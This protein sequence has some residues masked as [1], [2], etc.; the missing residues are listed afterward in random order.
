MKL[1]GL[2]T[3]VVITCCVNKAIALPRGA[4]IGECGVIEEL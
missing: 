1:P 2:K 4:V 3:G